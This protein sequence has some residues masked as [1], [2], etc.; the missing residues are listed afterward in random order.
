M[1]VNQIFCSILHGGGVNA[2]RRNNE[3]A[4]NANFLFSKRLYELYPYK[5]IISMGSQ[6]EY[7]YYTKRVTENDKLNPQNSYGRVKIQTCQWLQNYCEQHNI[8]WQW[9]RIFTIFGEG[10]RGGLIPAA[11]AKCLS[12]DEI[13]E[14]TKGEQVYSFLYAPDFAKALMNVIGAKGKSGIYNIS[15]PRNEY[16]IRDVLLRIKELTNSKIEIK[17]GALPYREDQVMFMAGNTDKFENAFGPF[18]NT[19]FNQALLHEIE[20]MK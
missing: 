19:D 7:G 9:L 13:F 3:C 2:E 12:K 15:Q 20:S 6:A 4:Q 16:Q 18:P 5:Q 1:L 8:E 10:Q 14:T 17:F 11:I